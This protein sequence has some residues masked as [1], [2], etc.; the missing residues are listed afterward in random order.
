MSIGI[1][2]DDV[3]MYNQGVSF[4]K[5]DHVGTFKDRNDDSF[6]MNDGCDEFI[7]NLVPV[8]IP[9]ERGPLG[10]L[11]QMQE[12]GRDQGHTLMALGLAAD[13]CTVGLNQGDDLFAYMNDRIAAGAEFVAAMNFGGVSAG[14]LPWKPYDYADC[15]GTLGAAWRM[16]GPNT[17]G[18]GEKRPYWD[19]ILGYYEGMR[20]VK[21]QYAE[22]ASAAVGVDGGGGNYSQNS[23]GFDHLGFSTLTSY[24]PAV[25]G[26][27]AITPLYGDI[28]YKGVTYK[29]QTNLGGLKYK[30]DSGPSKAIPADG[31]DITLMPQL[32][33]DAEDSGLWIWSTGETT[34]NITVK[35]DHSYIYRVCYTAD[36]G[37]RSYQSFAI[38][39]CGD[40]KPDLVSY[41][42]TANNE[43]VSDTTVTVLC[44]SSVKLKVS[45]T[46]GWTND[47]LWDNGTKAS[48]VTINTIMSSRTYTC[49]YANQSGAVS[50]AVFKINVVSAMPTINGNEF[51]G[52][53]A[54]TQVL[55]GSTVTLGLSIPDAA[56]PE[57]V[58]WSNG[59]TGT[60]VTMT[61]VQTDLQITATY[62]GQTFSYNIFVKDTNHSY[63]AMLTAE[64]GYQ[65]VTSDEQLAQLCPDHY[66]V[67]ATDEADLLL[68]LK[69]APKNGN[70]AFMLSEPA[71]FTDRNSFVQLFQIE[72]YNNGYTIRN[73]DYDGLTLQT[74]WNHPEQMRTHDQPFAC[75]WSLLLL[76]YT[77][78]AWTVEN[79]KYNGNYL[80][81][82][83]TAN[84]LRDGEELA[85][86]KGE[87]D[88]LR[89][90]IFA[91]E[92]SQFHTDY[93]ESL[94]ETNPEGVDAT[95]FLLNPEFMGKGFGW[96]MN[97]TWGNQRYNGAAEVWHSK[98]FNLSQEMYGLPD[99]KYT[100]TCQMSNG[101]GA[102]TGFLFA[103]SGTETKKAVVEASSI[104]SNFDAERDK[105]A[106]NTNYGLLKVDIQVTGGN[107]KIGINDPSDGTNWIV[108]DNFTLTY[109]GNTTVG[110][111]E[112]HR[113]PDMMTD[114]TIYDLQGRV[115]KH[116]Q[117]HG[118]YI[119]NGRKFISK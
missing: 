2:C 86:N 64:K 67:L 44:G 23:G 98:N 84:G 33:E 22:K 62:L 54:E 57:S 113:Q 101:D 17:G 30:Y 72:K 70:K 51:I 15:R 26:Q 59:S 21:M 37:A 77:D 80:G 27:E 109:H 82:W 46:T 83:T 31:A 81:L 8:T 116:P 50:Q 68:T 20:G 47:Y 111:E 10:Y 49:Q 105:M 95:P 97:G 60:S 115:I 28:Q 41:E 18:A 42:I 61:D 69:D 6:I 88:M 52:S 107:L 58:I 48:S 4:Y 108:W 1:L 78:G 7:G 114:R 32:P 85:C 94:N 99:G 35:A 71:D 11:G 19:R 38:A 79:G 24:R 90:Q 43:T 106:A 5:Y 39:V 91:V 29:N 76:E 9:D 73:V 103:T 104:G 14:S 117:K 13:I 63:Y 40:A 55:T 96:T 65:I 56:D 45:P 93:L 92:R 118:I 36:N 25:S 53:Q 74:E 102:N 3:H 89:L 66:F 12:S 112:I 100:V 16:N 87:N 75:E 119:M 110:I 34:R